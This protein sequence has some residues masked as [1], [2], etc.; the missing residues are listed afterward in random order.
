M[1]KNLTHLIFDE[2]H[3]RGKD[4]DF[5]LIAIR[6]ALQANPHL[7]I[8]LMSATLDAEQLSQYFGGCPVINV[9][10]RLF[11]V[12][13]MYL[14]DVLMK[15]D[16]QFKNTAY[17]EHL[18]ERC[19][20]DDADT[21]AKM[22]QQLTLDA[23]QFTND[24][25]HIDHEL[26]HHVISHIHTHD[27]T[28]GSILVFLPGYDDIMKQ[29]RMIETKFHQENYQLFVLHSGVNRDSNFQHERIYDRMPTGVRKIILS[30]NIAET[31]VTIKDVVC[32][33]LLTSSRGDHGIPNI[34][35]KGKRNM[36]SS[37]L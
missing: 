19:D 30:T 34:F 6:D 13:T 28:D 27:S 11:D 29:K 31:S 37:L 12:E 8:I 20:G 32:S 10:G 36:L 5:L 9:P 23:Y 15:T 22:L 2:V 25:T 21:K 14:D 35:I 33:N 17:V 18:M 26:L 3:E 4:T 16:Y 1:Y 7:K 24:P